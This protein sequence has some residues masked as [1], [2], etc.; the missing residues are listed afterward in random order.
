[1][2][3]LILVLGMTVILVLSGCQ[4]SNESQPVGPLKTTITLLDIP[5]ITTPATGM[6][7][8]FEVSTNNQY[9]GTVVWEPE[10]ESTF[11]PEISYSATV[12]LTPKA[13]YTLAGIIQNTFRIS[14]S[15]TVTHSAESGVVTAQFPETAPLSDVA[16][17][18]A[19][20][21]SSGSL[22][23][24]FNTE[25]LY[26]SVTLPNEINSLTISA[27]ASDT[28][29]T[30]STNVGTP[31]DLHIG[32]NPIRVEVTAENGTKLNYFI[33]AGRRAVET[34]TPT[35]ITML[36]IPP[37]R[38]QRSSG[39]ENISE[40]THTYKIS[41]YEITRSQF[42]TVFPGSDPSDTIR[43][44][45]TNHPVQRVSW[46]QAIAFCNK[47]SLLEGLTP[48]YSVE[49]IN[50]SELE[51]SDIPSTFDTV[52]NAASEDLTADGYRLPTEM[53]W[54]W[55]AMGAPADGQNGNTNTTGYLKSFA[56]S[57]GSNAITTF[58][59]FYENS[60]PGNS[61]AE[62]RTTRP[63]GT[64]LPNELGLYDMTGNIWEWCWDAYNNYP[65]G[66]ISD[67]RSTT[68]GGGRVGHG[69]SWYCDS[70]FST[71]TY[72]ELHGLIRSPYEQ[73]NLIGFRVVQYE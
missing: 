11:L 61:S 7:P 34:A 36:S 68:G 45:E 41:A 59:V 39:P 27:T 66:F 67:Y 63:V 18:A 65:T 14:G 5:G 48:V 13:G 50:W 71:L 21:V 60:G 54:M 35:G 28:G 43:S 56:G 17:L 30:L 73:S 44:P 16:T 46:Y 53:E 2:K 15:E 47:L 29:A 42:T 33:T 1:M 25:T 23:P 70:T 20:S 24:D 6:H 62:T 40:I 19:L 49:G 69:G 3:K 58:A 22:E 38:F 32:A 9:T 52:W 8:S 31:L 37:G 57:N 4:Q 51:F 12:T 72:R 64:K 26:Y 10:I 55:A